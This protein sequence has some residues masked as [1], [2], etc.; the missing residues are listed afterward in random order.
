MTFTVFGDFPIFVR[1][2]FEARRTPGFSPISNPWI[3][4]YV[5]NDC[6]VGVFVMQEFLFK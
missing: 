3:F 5:I 4:K 2:E 1:S 6:T